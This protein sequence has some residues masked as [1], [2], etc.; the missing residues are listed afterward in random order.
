MAQRTPTGSSRC[1][2]LEPHH[3]GM[4]LASRSFLSPLQ[5]V[6]H[7]PSGDVSSALSIYMW[8]LTE[9]WGCPRCGQ[10]AV[11]TPGTASPMGSTCLCFP[12][13]GGSEH[14]GS[15]AS[16]VQAITQGFIIQN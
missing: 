6:C 4:G 14:W 2:L 15:K 1:F 3:L 10:R 7:K 5:A 9:V 16:P 13:H 12:S 8:V 11:C